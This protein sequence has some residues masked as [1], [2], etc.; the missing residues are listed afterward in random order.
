MAADGVVWVTYSH[1]DPGK[2][3]L[4]DAFWALAAAPP[5]HF[6]VRKLR[7]VRFDRDVFLESDGLDEQRA[8]V[9]FYELRHGGGG[10]DAPAA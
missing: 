10:G 9:Y 1:H 2:A 7:E 4:D 3:A 8:V 5:F 6:V